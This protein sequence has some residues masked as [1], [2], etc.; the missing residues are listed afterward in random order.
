MSKVKKLAAIAAA[1]LTAAAGALISAAPA[2]SASAGDVGVIAVSGWVNLPAFPSVVETGPVH[3]E[4]CVTGVVASGG[5]AH[6]YSDGHADPTAAALPSGPGETD[7]Q[8]PQQLFGLSTEDANPACGDGVADC[9]SLTA[10]FNYLE[11]NPALV[12]FAEGQLS[13]WGFGS[14]G[15]GTAQGTECFAWVRV[16]LTAVVGIA[17][18][19]GSCAT[20]PV[21]NHDPTVFASTDGAAVAVFVPLVGPGN[22][23][24]SGPG[25][26]VSAYVQA[27]GAFGP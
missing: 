5:T 21:V 20:T 19:V 12:G 7:C 1:T 4:L 23:P 6:V 10:D 11:P 18:P 16:G 15:T 27:V 17:D 14:D 8:G 13:L 22:F 3:A 2:A 9:G 24:L 26:K 25:G